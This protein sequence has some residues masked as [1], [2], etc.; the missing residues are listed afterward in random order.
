MKSENEIFSICDAHLNAQRHLAFG[1]PGRIYIWKNCYIIW[2][3]VVLMAYCQCDERNVSLLAKSDRQ[4]G[5]KKIGL[6]KIAK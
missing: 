4:R 6:C 1:L 2:K 5:N 3:N